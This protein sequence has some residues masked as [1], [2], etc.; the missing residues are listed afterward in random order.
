MQREATAAEREAMERLEQAERAAN[1]AR[2][3]LLAVLRREASRERLE[4]EQA[5]AS[6]S[7]GGG[8]AGAISGA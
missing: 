7:D 2:Q 4:Q 6:P 5:A 8:A 3:H 1:E